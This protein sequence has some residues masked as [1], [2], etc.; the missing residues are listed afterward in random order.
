M[1]LSHM[2]KEALKTERLVIKSPEIDDKVELTQLINDYD[3]VQWLSNMPFPY[4]PE[5]AEAF[6]ERSQ[7]KILKQEIKTYLI[8]HNKKM[9]GGIELR[10]FNKHSCELGYW[11]GKKYWGK[12][13]ATEAVGRLLELG[14]DELNLNE[15]YAAYKVG[16]KASKKVLEK[17][18]FQF[19][20]EKQEF[21]SVLNK[22]EQLIEMVK[23][24]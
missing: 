20:R 21:D 19:Y 4:K 11:L 23:R 2:L 18:G 16:N 22:N 15:I 10:D 24:K 14:F 5:D 9:L 3:V 1:R 12:G 6:I 13:F 17:S 7:E 8:F